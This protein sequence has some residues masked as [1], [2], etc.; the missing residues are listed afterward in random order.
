MVCW[1]VEGESEK[2]EGELGRTKGEWRREKARGEKLD[3]N[4]NNF[5]HASNKK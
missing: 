2:R 5:F 3:F 4:F 1:M